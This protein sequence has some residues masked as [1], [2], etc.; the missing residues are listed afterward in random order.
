VTKLWYC[1]TT[2]RSDIATEQE[3]SLAKPTRPSPHAMI[4]AQGC[5]FDFF[6]AKFI[7]FGFFNFFS[8]FIFEKSS[9]EILI[10]VAFF[11]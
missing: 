7:I 1:D 3:R 5:Q 4:N 2:K 6:E 8:F 10:F 9:N 11:G